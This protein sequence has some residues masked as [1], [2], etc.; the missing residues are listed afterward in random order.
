[1]TSKEMRN[2][3][4]FLRNGFESAGRWGIPVIKKQDIPLENVGLIAFSD[5]R[6]KA[7]IKDLS[8][9]AITIISYT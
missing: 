8:A 4:L 5:T 6:S 9:L 3:P 1:M 7:S 2:N